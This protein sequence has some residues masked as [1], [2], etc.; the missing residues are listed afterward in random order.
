MTRHRRSFHPVNGTRCHLCGAVLDH[1]HVPHP[2]WQ[3]LAWIWHSHWLWRAYM[4]AGG[5]ICLTLLIA[6]GR[7]LAAGQ[8]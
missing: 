8:L 7:L 3:I 4:V 1:T 2:W 6:G 5:V